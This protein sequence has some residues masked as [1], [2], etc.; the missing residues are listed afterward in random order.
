MPTSVN[1]FKLLNIRTQY[2]YE[3]LME[4]YIAEVKSRGHV[5]IHTQMIEST[6]MEMARFMTDP[7][8][9]RFSIMLCGIVGNGKSTAHKAFN[10]VITLLHSYKLLVAKDPLTL[11]AKMLQLT[12]AE[13]AKWEEVL[14]WYGW[15]GI[16][17]M[18]S[19]P[20]ESKIYGRTVSCVADLLEYRYDKCKSTIVTTNLTS[21][22]IREKYGIRASDRVNDSMKVIIFGDIDFRKLNNP[23]RTDNNNKQQD[24]SKL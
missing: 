6:L 1:N 10:R 4:A 12:A 21:S 22:E 14:N 18:G 5:F 17:D 13:P 8:D 16:E 20:C 7:K 9:C 23:E 19:E 3:L 2:V 24:T 11:N 15:L